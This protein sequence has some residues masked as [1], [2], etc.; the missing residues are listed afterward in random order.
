M[1]VCVCVQY[2]AEYLEVTR[3]LIPY[4][5]YSLWNIPYGRC[6]PLASVFPPTTGPLAPALSLDSLSLPPGCQLSSV[7]L[8]MCATAF[9]LCMGSR[10]W[11]L[12]AFVATAFTH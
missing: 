1:C 6:K 2:A 9:G 5:I 3:Q 4:G 7:G 10:D 11:T 8:Q 12:L